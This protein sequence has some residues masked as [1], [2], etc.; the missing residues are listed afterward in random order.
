M[1]FWWRWVLAELQPATKCSAQCVAWLLLGQIFLHTDHCSPFLIPPCFEFFGLFAGEDCCLFAWHL[2]VGP[3]N[4]SLLQDGLRSTSAH[5]RTTLACCFVRRLCRTAH[6]NCVLLFLLLLFC[7]WWTRLT[8]SIQQQHRW[9]AI[10]EIR[11]L[12]DESPTC[13]LYTSPSPR[14]RG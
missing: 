5:T 3:N 8:S 6:S 1:C 2:H 10:R 9:L 4:H 11:C 14:D 12:C 13:L 7:G